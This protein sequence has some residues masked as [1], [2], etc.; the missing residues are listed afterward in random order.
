MKSN[1]KI[2]LNEEFEMDGIEYVEIL[3]YIIE[4]RPD[5]VQKIYDMNP[6]IILEDVTDGFELLGVKAGLEF[7][8]AQFLLN[9]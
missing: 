7:V 8:R 1:V 6:D 2:F 5:Q 3:I 4:P 9:K